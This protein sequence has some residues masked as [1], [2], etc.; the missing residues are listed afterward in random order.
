VSPCVTDLQLFFW[1]GVPITILRSRR[2]ASSEDYLN[3]NHGPRRPPQPDQPLFAPRIGSEGSHWIIHHLL[4]EKAHRLAASW[5][6]HCI[7][8]PQSTVQDTERREAPCSSGDI[9]RDLFPSERHDRLQYRSHLTSTC[10][11]LAVCQALHPVGPHSGFGSQLASFVSFNN[12]PLVHAIRY[13]IKP[14][15]GCAPSPCPDSRCV[16]SYERRL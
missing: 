3:A 4:N 8:G 13:Q 15:P 7:S 9:C 2:Y 11:S 14:G 16:S 6:L 1:C 10:I 12:V 5:R